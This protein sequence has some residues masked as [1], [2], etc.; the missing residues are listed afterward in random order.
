MEINDPV[1]SGILCI[2]KICLKV[3][4]EAGEDCMVTVRWKHANMGDLLC[5]MLLLCFESQAKNLQKVS[6]DMQKR[7]W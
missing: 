6:F 4:G 3:M 7:K 5:S 2:T 1:N